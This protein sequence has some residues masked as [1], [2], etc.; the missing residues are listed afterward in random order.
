MKGWRIF[1]SRKIPLSLFGTDMN[2]HGFLHFWSTFKCTYHLF[3]IMSVYRSDICYPHI[4]KQHTRNKK[5]F[6][7]IL[8]TLDTVSKCISYMWFSQLCLNILFKLRIIGACPDISQIFWHS[9]YIFRYRHLI[10]IENDNQIG[11]QSRRIVECLKCH[12]SR[13]CSVT[14]NSKYIIFFFF[15]FPCFCHS[16]CK[17]YRCWT[18]SRIKCVTITFTSLW[19]STHSSKLSECV[20]PLFSACKKFVRITLMSYIP[21]QTII[22]KIKT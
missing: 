14:Y 13:Q 10:V 1:L 18:V 6:D 2:Y 7:C 17:T 8:C 22:W 21:H 15:K 5:S 11:F 4:F 19:K 9:T 12:S 20:K 3:Y 16:Y